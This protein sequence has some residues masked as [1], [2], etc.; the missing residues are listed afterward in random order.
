[1]ELKL[2]TSSSLYLDL[3]L[4]IVPYGIETRN[5][6]IHNIISFL[7]IVPYGIETAAKRQS[8]ASKMYF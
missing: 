6:F 8:A 2:A 3:L 5:F 7:L 4:L 1:M